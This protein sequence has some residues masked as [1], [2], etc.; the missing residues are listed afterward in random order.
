MKKQ[1]KSFLSM[2]LSAALL[3]T[4]AACGNSPSAAETPTPS[5]EQESPA[6]DPELPVNVMVLNGTTGFGMA[7]LI[8]DTE[9]GNSAL[10]YQFSVETDPTNV[11]G[12]LIN[13]TADIAALPT[14]AASVVYNKTQGEVQVLALNTLG[15]LYL[16]TDGSVTVDSFEDLKGQTVYAPAQNPTFI[17]QYLCEQNGLTVGE[18]IFIDNTYAQPTDLRTALAAGE[19]SLA[20]LPEP[21]VTIAKSGND[22]LVT[23]MDLTE[24]WEKVSPENSLVQ[25]CVVVRKEFAQAHPAEVA[26]FLE[27]YGASIAF[28]D[29]DAE[30]VGA[31]IEQSG[32]FAKGAV[33]VKALPQC[34]ICFLTGEDMKSSMSAFLE[35]M[36]EQAPASI[37]GALPGDDFYFIG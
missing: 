21:M 37:G 26:Q 13:G 1:W 7:K 34:N 32:V 24:E 3:C 15:V 22:A 25:G 31:A 17:F 11:T 30:T 20:V 16:M 9:A 6:V 18:D 23:A 14:N 10:Q 19:V 2:C 5:P 36:M 33:A 27:D 8:T 29:G 28:L 4:L 12:A 35:I